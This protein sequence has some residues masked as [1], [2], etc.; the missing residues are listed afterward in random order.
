MLLEKNNMVCPAPPAPHRR[1]GPGQGRGG[2]GP[3]RALPEPLTP[4]QSEKYMVKKTMSTQPASARFSSPSSPMPLLLC[5]PRRPRLRAHHKQRT[6]VLVLESNTHLLP[7]CACSMHQE[8]GALEVLLRWRGNARARRHV[9]RAHRRAVAQGAC[10][11][12]RL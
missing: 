6:H 12:V 11:L 4:F 3:G 5:I 10:A 1:R 9:L 7:V 2:T 8:M